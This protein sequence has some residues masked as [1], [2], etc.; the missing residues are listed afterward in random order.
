MLTRQQH[1]H[2]DHDADAEAKQQRSQLAQRRCRAAALNRL[3]QVAHDEWNGKQG[4][5]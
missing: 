1:L 3:P 4:D 2:A 5:C